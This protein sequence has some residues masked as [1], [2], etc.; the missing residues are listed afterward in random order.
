MIVGVSL[1]QQGPAVV[2]PFVEKFGVNY[3][4]V[5]GDAKIASAFGGIEALPTTFVIDRSGKIVR[6]HVGYTNAETFEKDIKPLL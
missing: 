6:T 5:M 3:P 2:R 1:D 4:I